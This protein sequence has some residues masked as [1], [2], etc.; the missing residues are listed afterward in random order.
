[1]Y[2]NVVYMDPITNETFM[3]IHFLQVF[4]LVYAFIAML[5]IR[6]LNLQGNVVV[7]LRVG[8]EEKVHQLKEKILEQLPLE[9]PCEK[10]ILR[11]DLLA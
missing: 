9:H 6:V 2:V 3:Q 11:A 10:K 4:C 5:E 7:T 1:M 8:S